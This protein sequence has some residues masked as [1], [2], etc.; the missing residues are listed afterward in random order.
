MNE[1]SLFDHQGKILR[2][3]EQL[4]NF[5]GCCREVVAAMFGRL[6]IGILNK[7]WPG[8]LFVCGHCGGKSELTAVQMPAS[9]T[10]TEAAAIHRCPLCQER[11]LL[12]TITVPET[13]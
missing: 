2:F 6:S 13:D 8:S 3:F 7:D 12:S 10:L 9:I 4:C 5:E 1:F 11:S